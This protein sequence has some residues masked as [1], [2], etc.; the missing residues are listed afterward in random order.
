MNTFKYFVMSYF[1]IDTVFIYRTVIVTT[2]NS[3]TNKY[4]KNSNN[5][6]FEYVILEYV[7]QLPGWTRINYLSAADSVTRRRREIKITPRPVR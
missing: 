6:V 1:R 7:Y 5:I 3:L 4:G 2:L